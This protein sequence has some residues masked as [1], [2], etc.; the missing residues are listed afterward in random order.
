M[1]YRAGDACS[2]YSR[3]LV[4]AEQ[5]LDAI[6]A[7]DDG[8]VRALLES[9]V[10]SSIPREVREEALTIVALPAASYRAPMQLLRL[11]HRLTHLL[12]DSDAEAALAQM[13]I[14]FGMGFGR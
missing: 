3:L 2:E 11:H 12:R 8:V 7:R 1:S 13:E 4:V 6:S 14:P 5:L 10:A 9:A